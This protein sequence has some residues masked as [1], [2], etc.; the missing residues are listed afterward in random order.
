MANR[1]GKN[2]KISNKTRQGGVYTSTIN[3][4]LLPLMKHWYDWDAKRW[5]L[6][7]FLNVNLELQ[8]LS[9]FCRLFHMGITWCKKYFWIFVWLNSG[10][11]KL[12]FVLC[13]VLCI[14]DGWW[15]DNCWNI[16]ENEGYL[17]WKPLLKHSSHKLSEKLGWFI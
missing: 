4:E 13:L 3:L 14:W 12:L 16:Y 10:V 15:E 1:A 8:F 6:I 11:L 5:L 9:E 17:Y 7:C 2:S